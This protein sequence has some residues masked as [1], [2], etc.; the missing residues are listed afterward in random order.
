VLYDERQS[1][2]EF[3]KNIEINFNELEI[4]II[5][6]SDVEKIPEK[7]QEQNILD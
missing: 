4:L 3:I 5:K 7:F 6:T 1:I 2:S